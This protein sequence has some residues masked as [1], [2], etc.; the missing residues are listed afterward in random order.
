MTRRR[1]LAAGA[2]ATVTASAVA[3]ALHAGDE[4][5]EA[6]RWREVFFD[7]FDGSDLDPEAWGRYS[8][9]GNAGIG[10]REPRQVTV[11][12]SQLRIVASGIVGGGLWNRRDLRY[13][14]WEVRARV[15]R[16]AGYGPAILLWPTSDNW[17]EEG[18][19][20][21]AEIPRGDRR[22]SHFTVHWGADNRQRSHASHADFTDWHVF[23]C[24]WE[25][26]VV[27]Y[28]LDGRPQWELRVPPEA[29]PRRPM[30]LALQL[31][32]GAEGSWIG[33]RDAAT[34]QTVG[35]YVDWVRISQRSSSAV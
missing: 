17:P 19:I 13:G 9:R 28:L 23:C 32:V 24:E 15:D 8:G 33:P 6:P 26:D 30:H 22:V 5:A 1:F 29:V 11:A 10:W 35:L 14:R 2:G 34:P 4:E 27:R 18:E 7:D 3:L 16:G 12:E 25:R 20:D 31:D 21:I